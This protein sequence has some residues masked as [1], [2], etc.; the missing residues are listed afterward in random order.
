L[1]TV[2][3]FSWPTRY[4]NVNNGQGT[5]TEGLTDTWWADT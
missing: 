3:D 1:K 4:T 5:A 2:G